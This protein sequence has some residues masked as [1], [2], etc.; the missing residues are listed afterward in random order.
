MAHQ[1]TI[2]VDN[3]SVL[4]TLRSLFKSMDGVSI[5]PQPRV[6]K[7]TVVKA[8]EPDMTK[9]EILESIDSAFKELKLNLEGKLEFKT[10]EE[11]LD[12]L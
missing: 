10:L 3:P 5:I 11:A 6:R 4:R 2:S 9:E 8:E 1:M 12:E 7:K